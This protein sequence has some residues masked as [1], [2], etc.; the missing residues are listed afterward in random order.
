MTSST[1]TRRGFMGVV[2]AAGL[3]GLLCAAS[4]PAACAELGLGPDSR[5]LVF[6]TE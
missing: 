5:V 6:V 3:A 4:D 1:F 2:G